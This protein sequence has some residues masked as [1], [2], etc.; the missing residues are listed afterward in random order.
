MRKLSLSKRM[1]WTVFV[2]CAATAI[3]SPAQTLT[4][5]YSFCSQTNCA[6]GSMPEAGLVQATDGNF[7]GT[8]S[9]YG[10]SGL[11]TVFK[12]TPSGTLTTLHSFDFSDGAHP[13][14]GLI[15][16]T[17]GNFYGTAGA[18]ANS[19]GTIFKITPSG[20]LSTL[21][22]FCPQYPNCPDGSDPSAGLIQA[23]DGNFYG[24]T[25][26]GGANCEP[27]GCGTVF[28][29]TPSGTLITL[30][31]F[32]SQTN[33]AD[34]ANP[35]AGLIQ[36]TDGNFYGTTSGFATGT[37]S[38]VFKITPSGTLTTLYT[39]CSQPNCADGSNLHAGLIQ[40]TDGNFYGT[41]VYGGANGDGTVFK[42]TPNGT[43]AVLYS[44]CSQ[45]NC[46]D[47]GHP[48][49]GLSK[50]PTATSTGQPT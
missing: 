17:D 50:P 23:T 44:F 2:F 41:T 36:A 28:K 47:G 25:V 31:S 15:Q 19:H 38:T 42:I 20:R 22:S 34:G 1:I 24:T 8:T 14:A 46:T 33:C 11:G 26:D 6:D 9:G 10:S 32:C 18:G 12:I 37:N 3:A 39:F 43:E 49:L 45:A 48:R 16:A 29:I 35:Y 5:L 4:T 13:S 40:A 7:Y 30:Y 27:V 21:Y